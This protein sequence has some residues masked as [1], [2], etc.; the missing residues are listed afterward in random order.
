MIAR[1]ALPNALIPVITV[2]GLQLG[3][4]LAGA[5][6]VETVFAWPGV[7]RLV[8]SS[9]FAKDYVVVQAAVMLYAITYVLANRIV[10]IAYTWLD[11][12]M[13]LA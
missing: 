12:Q 13:E 6:I 2:A 10:D 1:H 9:I 8:V 11:P 5:V 3:H 4:L 7:G